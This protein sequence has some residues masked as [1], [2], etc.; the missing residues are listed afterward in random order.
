MLMINQL[1][2]HQYVQYDCQGESQILEPAQDYLT[3]VEAEERSK[4]LTYERTATY[5]INHILHFQYKVVE[6]VRGEFS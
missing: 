3:T 5:I 4:E 6:I 2:S 1:T